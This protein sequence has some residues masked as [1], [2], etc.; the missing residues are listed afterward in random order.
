VSDGARLSFARLESSQ[1]SKKIYGR[2]SELSCSYVHGLRGNFRCHPVAVRQR[3]RR[4]GQRTV[5]KLELLKTDKNTMASC[6][7][8][9]YSCTTS[10]LFVH[11]AL[12]DATPKALRTV[13][14]TEVLV[15]R[16][17]DQGIRWQSINSEFRGQSRRPKCS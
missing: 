10:K 7:T 2:I 8:P 3:V 15:D 17:E 1:S 6:T 11:D 16:Q 4:S 9:W 12:A 5:G 14:K 13:K